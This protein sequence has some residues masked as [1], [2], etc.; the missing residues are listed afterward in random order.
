[1]D[2]VN[3]IMLVGR[4]VQEPD[5]IRLINGRPM[6]TFGLET[7]LS[8]ERDGQVHSRKSL[9][10]VRCWGRLADYV[11]QRAKAGRIFHVE[12]SLEFWFS[13]A[14]VCHPYVSAVFV[15]DL[16]QGG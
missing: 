2:W 16:G 7:V 9:H 12:G 6:A 11:R 15:R 14:G 8:W 1:M 13:S 4:V 10:T 5:P 3:R